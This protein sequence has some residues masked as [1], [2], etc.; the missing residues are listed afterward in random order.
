[1]TAKA[2]GDSQAPEV[3]PSTRFERYLVERLLKAGG[4]PRV[5]V[6]LWDGVAISTSPLP[7]VGD[8]EIRSRATLY[9]LILDPA[10]AFGD[11]FSDGSIEIAGSLVDVLTEVFAAR[12]NSPPSG[13]L[14]RL[15]AG[16]RRPRSHS[17]SDSRDCIHHHYDIGNDF[18]RLW[19]DERMQY[20]CAYFPEPQVTLEQAQLAKLD[21]V[22]RKLQLQP[23]QTVLEAGCGWGGL[24]IRM[25]ERWGARVK[26]FSLSHEQVEL[27]RELARQ[28]GLTGQVEFVEDDYRNAAGTYDAF[29][30][31]GMLEHVGLENYRELGR[32]IDRCLAPHGRGL[33][34]SIGRN[35]P[36]P[37]DLWTAT[38]IFPGAYAPSL[39]EMLG[40]LEPWRLSVLDVENLR[41]HYALT[42]KH[43]LAR[44]DR[45]AD[46]VGQVFD[47]TFVRMWRLYLAASVAAF[48]AGGLQ[49]FQ[50]VFAR[51]TDQ[52]IPLT[53]D[54]L[55]RGP[56]EC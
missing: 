35:A 45:V 7:A 40:V 6:V 39:R 18:Y 15:L 51:E 32:V 29:V 48:Q 4:N 2:T 22:C 5:R 49:L 54:H 46:A 42:L 34:H 37:F 28:K 17:I 25:A 31:V 3:K 1:M 26:A 19:L 47:D 30:S 21:H 43:W 53:R 10:L 55:Y 12:K 50:V 13:A 56:A 27:A 44:F 11:S 52:L 36:Q 20:S 24:A 33:L 9:R 41:L 38:R 23:G 16:W 14:T 8:V